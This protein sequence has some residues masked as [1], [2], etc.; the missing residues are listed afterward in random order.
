MGPS[1][2][3]EA[4]PNLKEKIKQ[5]G[6]LDAEAQKAKLDQL[7]Q[8]FERIRAGK[9]E[10]I[11]DTEADI[12]KRLKPSW[13]HGLDIRLA[14]FGQACRLPV[15]STTRR[16]ANCRCPPKEA[17][18]VYLHSRLPDSRFHSCQ[19]LHDFRSGRR[20]SGPLLQ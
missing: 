16:H 13:K 12:I 10:S 11:G 2:R 18:R 17:M 14:P 15:R 8:K 5:L 4:G 20:G 6:E 9:S 1:D 7:L 3:K 19:S